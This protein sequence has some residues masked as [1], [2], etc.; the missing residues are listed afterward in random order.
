MN[1]VWHMVFGGAAYYMGAV[2][3]MP[4]MVYQLDGDDNQFVDISEFLTG[5]LITWVL[6]DPA[7]QRYVIN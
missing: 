7:S 6:L 2:I 1:S 5:M 3:W 4:Y